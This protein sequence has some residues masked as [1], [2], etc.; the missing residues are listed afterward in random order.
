VKYQLHK[1]SGRKI[2]NLTFTD[3]RTHE[4]FKISTGQELKTE[5]EKFVFEYFQ[6]YKPGQGKHT[7]TVGDLMQLMLGHYATHKPGRWEKMQQC[8]DNRMR[9]KFQD[10][11]ARELSFRDIQDYKD[12][13]LGENPTGHCWQ[14]IK[15]PL[16][17]ST[18]NRDLATLS[19]MYSFSYETEQI[20]FTGPKFL[21]YSEKEFIRKGYV[22]QIE[23]DRMCAANPPVWLRALMEVA[24]N[25][26]NR[27]G[28]L[29]NL[30]VRQCDFIRG[31]IRFDQDDTKNGEGRSVPMTPKMR[32]LLLICCAGKNQEGYVFTRVDGKQVG[33]FRR[34]W[35]TLLENAGIDRRVLFHDFRRSA[36]S[37]MVR[38]GID[39]DVAMRISGHKTSEVFR[40][41]NIVF[42]KQVQDAA[43]LIQAGAESDR[44]AAQ[45]LGPIQ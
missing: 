9:D 16:Q 27:R 32:E 11:D 26:A 4:R 33:D 6:A 30:R 8:W 21:R 29:V 42:E 25:V 13:C 14:P 38:R 23:F 34:L 19:R 15:Y 18:V 35:R 41:Y 40:R 5:A 1:P 7:Q 45:E 22:T 20:N 2:F 39:R 31:M 28:E 10:I 37:N 3:P 24:Y 36:V 43:L 12:W 17:K 44:E